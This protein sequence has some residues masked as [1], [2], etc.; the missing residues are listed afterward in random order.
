MRR[1]IFFQFYFIKSHNHKQQLL[2]STL[3]KLL[4]KKKL[5]IYK[6]FTK[7]LKNCWTWSH[8]KKNALFQSIKL[9]RLCKSL[10]RHW[11]ICRIISCCLVGGW[12]DGP[13]WGFWGFPRGGYGNCRGH[14]SLKTQWPVAVFLTS[15][16]AHVHPGIHSCNEKMF[17]IIL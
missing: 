17:T 10:C 3:I 14:W 9:S 4:N 1:C 15:P 7:R 8:L 11:I 12:V 6:S 16:L 13:W 2:L 5:Y